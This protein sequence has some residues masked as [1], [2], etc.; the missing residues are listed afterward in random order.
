MPKSTLSNQQCNYLLT[1]FESFAKQFTNNNPNNSSSSSSSPSS[2]SSLSS[3]SYS[4]LKSSNHL[5]PC[6]IKS[7]TLNKY[8]A[9]NHDLVDK[10]S[11]IEA[12]KR[13]GDNEKE[14]TIA[15]HRN[16]ITLSN[17]RFKQK[18]LNIN[19]I[20]LASQLLSQPSKND[21]TQNAFINDYMTF[22]KDNQKVNNDNNNYN[23]INTHDDKTR[24]ESESKEKLTSDDLHRPHCLCDD[25]MRLSPKFLHIDDDDDE[26][27]DQEEEFSRDDETFKTSK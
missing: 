21:A 15:K 13:D 4:T 7:V 8:S 3:S 22:L 9:F 5:K 20:D 19:N 16:E 2:S 18:M 17:L 12:I 23:E 1:Q 24:L 26:D 14:Q 10:C 6:K 25:K 27:D 11:H